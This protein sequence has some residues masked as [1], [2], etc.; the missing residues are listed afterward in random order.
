MY[1]SNIRYLRILKRQHVTVKLTEGSGII[2][3]T[4]TRMNSVKR[5]SSVTIPESVGGIKVST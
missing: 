5:N 1:T 2:S 3:T 4:I